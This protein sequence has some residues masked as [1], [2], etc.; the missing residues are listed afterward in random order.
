MI[1]TVTEKNLHNRA[2]LCK[3]KVVK[4]QFYHG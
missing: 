3:L 2:L 4:E 1:E